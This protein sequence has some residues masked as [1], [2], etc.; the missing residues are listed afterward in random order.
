MESSQ[1]MAEPKA[2][3]MQLPASKSTSTL[4]LAERRAFMSLS[5]EE[6]R[7]LL[8]K[9]AGEMCKHYQQNTQ[10]QELEIGDIIDY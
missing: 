3:Q 6:R 9:Q 4:S 8:A 7:Q 1:P 10:W 2:E 5:L